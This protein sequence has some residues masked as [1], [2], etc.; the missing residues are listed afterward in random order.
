M[1]HVGAKVLFLAFFTFVTY[2][3]DSS[4]IVSSGRR[5]GPKRPRR[6]IS[7]SLVTSNGDTGACSLVGHSNCG[8]RTPSSSH[9]RGARRFRRVRRIHSGRLGGCMFT[10]FVRTTVSSSHNLPGVAS[11]RQGRV[12]ASGGSPRDLINRRK[13]AVIFH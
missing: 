3:G 11:H 5:P 8:R 2:S 10:L 4:R 9:R 7:N 12:G 1:G 6:R 13:R